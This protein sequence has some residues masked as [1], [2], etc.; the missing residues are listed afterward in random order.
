MK[1]KEFE[2]L[3]KKGFAAIPERFRSQIQN[4]VFIVENE[5]SKELLKKEELEQNETLLGYYHGIPATARG[6]SYGIGPTLPDTITIFQKPIED[7]A[8]NNPKLIENMV[9]DTIWHEIAHHFGI[10]EKEVRIREKKRRKN[11]PKN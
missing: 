8:G 4:V 1:R 6:D 11:P 3:V 7:I 2:K 10:D 5:P 9:A